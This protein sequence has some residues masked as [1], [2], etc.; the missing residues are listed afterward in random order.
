M[1]ATASILPRTIAALTA[2]LL[3][4]GLFAWMNATGVGVARVSDTL[5]NQAEANGLVWQWIAEITATSRNATVEPPAQIEGEPENGADNQVSCPHCGLW[6]LQN[7]QEEGQRR[8]SFLFSL[9]VLGGVVA[10]SR[11]ALR[12]I[13][14]SRRVRAG[15]IWRAPRSRS[16]HNLS[17]Q[18]SR[19]L[20]PRTIAVA[21][22][23]GLTSGLIALATLLSRQVGTDGVVLLNREADEIATKAGVFYAREGHAPRSMPVLS[24]SHSYATIEGS[25]IEY[26]GPYISA[27]ICTRRDLQDF[28]PARLEAKADKVPD[29]YWLGCSHCTPTAESNLATMLL[30]GALAGLIALGNGALRATRRW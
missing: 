2:L 24:Y 28:D 30:L 14:P 6:R 22:A 13:M 23:I 27:G 19:T 11:G 20:P 26:C 3:A 12:A 9:G 7:P 18:N 16:G 15:A 5:R 25:V 4:A 10:L 21:V 29:P 17:G 1:T 8:V